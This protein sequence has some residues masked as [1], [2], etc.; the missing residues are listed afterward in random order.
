M[1]THHEPNGRPA[2]SATDALPAVL[3]EP[4]VVLLDAVQRLSLARS[5][6]EIQEI[7]RPAARRLTG[8]DGVTFALRD[9]DACLYVDEDGREPLWKGTR[10][11]L[12]ACASGWTI[13][14]S[15]PMVVPDVD[16]DERASNE[17]DPTAFVRSLAVVPIGALDPIG[18]IGTHWMDHHEATDEELALLQAL[19][20]STAAALESADL[21]RNL[22]DRITRRT[23]ELAERSRELE[24]ASASV[25]ELLEEATVR[26]E[27]L[28]AAVDYHRAI[29]NI[30]AHEVR[31][32]LTASDLMLDEILSDHHVE[33]PVAENVADARRCIAEAVRIVEDQLH[34]AKLEAGVLRPRLDEVSI[35]DLYLALRGMVRALRRSPAVT[36]E[37]S[38]EEHLPALRTDAHMLGQILR[39]LVGNALKFTSD[40]IVLVSARFDH[41]ARQF[42]FEVSDTGIG[43]APDDRERIFEDFSQ[44]AAAQHARRAGTG[45]GLP[46]SRSLAVTL[47]GSL[48]LE[49]REGPGSTFVIRLPEKAP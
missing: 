15:S 34:R 29:L 43:V 33:G 23:S 7:V 41:L 12:E 1:L 16:A 45:L 27:D 5:L 10:V 9:D 26:S 35:P 49:D 18:A 19:A 24:D 40:G 31:S 25:R 39:N 14:H 22:E 21:W 11:P 20:D 44:V 48:E 37:F 46:L 8:S 38:S 47:G 42:V 4:A 17:P 30:L 36:L 28:E 3:G 2:T 6:A 13:L 32:P